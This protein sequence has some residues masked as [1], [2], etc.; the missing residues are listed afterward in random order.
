MHLTP[1]SA[2]LQALNNKALDHPTI[3]LYQAFGQHL[4]HLRPTTLR[5]QLRGLPATVLVDL[6]AAVANLPFAL[7]SSETNSRGSHPA[8]LLPTVVRALLQ[9]LQSSS[10]PASST[11]RLARQQRSTLHKLP[12][13]Y[14][15][16]LLSTCQQL[17]YL[18]E[19][20]G[21]P[22]CSVQ[23]LSAQLAAAAQT[24]LLSQAHHLSV[25]QL[26]GLLA[27][28]GNLSPVG[29]EP[30]VVLQAI[31]GLASPA[32]SGPDEL[33]QLA[34]LIQRAAQAATSLSAQQDASGALAAMATQLFT[35]V[36]LL[37]DGLQPEEGARHSRP[38]RGRHSRPLLPAKQLN[39]W[40]L[41]ALVQAL[42]ALASVP[43]FAQPQLACAAANLLTRC[44]TTWYGGRLAVRRHL[45]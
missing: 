44:I 3:A 19:A 28:L 7:S 29:P 1:A 22:A 30:S 25:Q 24:Y 37:S 27:A 15:I 39:A 45:A 21:T 2:C 33:P 18:E 17:S 36:M 43:G 41:P 9:P 4:Q 38:A 6:A 5:S 26:D 20:T 12:P 14:L 16:R 8:A 11:V 34:S 35:H 40:V 32:P 42:Q 31:S 23:P 13:Q 10:T